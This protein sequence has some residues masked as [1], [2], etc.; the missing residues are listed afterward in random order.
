MDN[1]G[2]LVDYTL[3]DLLLLMER[4]RDPLTGCPWDIQQTFSSIVPYTLEEAYEVADAISREDYPHLMDELG[5][6]LFQVIFYSQLGKEQQHF[7]F[8]DIVN[9]LVAKLL[10]RHPHVFPDGT[11]FS[12]RDPQVDISQEEIKASWERIKQQERKEKKLQRPDHLSV[13]SDTGWLDDI[14][15]SLPALKR[16]QKMQK[17]AAQ[18]GFDWP[19]VLP[20]VDKIHE[21]V[22]EL[23]DALADGT[24]GEVLEELGDLMFA[25]VNLARHLGADAESILA[26]SS[27]KFHRRFT[28][29]EKEL[30]KKSVSLKTASLA[31]MDRAWDTVKENEKAP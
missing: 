21:E 11:L 7:D 27:S 16:A 6:L 2:H 18:V 29:V 26:E 10:R 25:C 5:D 9:N 15:L 30:Q 20:V 13:P 19:S 24:S 28:H 31:E 4:L 17:R 23:D 12:S 14:P 3:K 8:A 1:S 22:R